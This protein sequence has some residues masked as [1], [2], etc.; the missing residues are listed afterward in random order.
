MYWYSESTAVQIRLYETPEGQEILVSE[1]MDVRLAAA[2]LLGVDVATTIGP[3]RLN[4]LHAR[5]PGDR[6]ALVRELRIR[7][8]NQWPSDRE[9][10]GALVDALTRDTATR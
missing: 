8:Q 7:G 10:R 4:E 3:T 6:D 5:W 2:H 9:R 1:D